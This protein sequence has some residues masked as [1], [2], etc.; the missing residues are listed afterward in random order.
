MSRFKKFQR[1]IFFFYYFVIFFN[2]T[3]ERYILFFDFLN[4]NSIESFF[5]IQK[6]QKIILSVLKKVHAEVTLDAISK[7][8]Y[9]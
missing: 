8:F 5:F 7:Y 9:E 3:V 4:S 1:L 6:I 2:D